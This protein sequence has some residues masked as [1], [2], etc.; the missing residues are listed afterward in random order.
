[1]ATLALA[2]LVATGAVAQAEHAVRHHQHSPARDDLRTTATGVLPK[3][4]ESMA[5]ANH[6]HT[7][8][9]AAASTRIIE[10][11]IAS[12]FHIGFAAQFEKARDDTSSRVYTSCRPG[13][14]LPQGTCPPST[15]LVKA[16]EEWVSSH[17]APE[18]VHTWL[19]MLSAN[20]TPFALGISRRVASL[21]VLDEVPGLPIAGTSTTGMPQLLSSQLGA[22][23]VLR[24]GV[25]SVALEWDV[26]GSSSALS[27]RCTSIT[28]ERTWERTSPTAGSASFATALADSLEWPPAAAPLRAAVS[29]A[30]R[31]I[32]ATDISVGGAHPIANT[33]THT[34]HCAR[35]TRK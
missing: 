11:S 19:G 16:A 12:S 13:S 33:H 17:N 24:A 5:V 3:K 10:A 26:A 7:G 8:G 15:A 21:T 25:T 22:H 28:P 1:M 4:S 23:A 31:T 9:P 34:R 14:A 18:L 29:S 20:S 2:A 30:L 27:L 35:S 6:L 32:D